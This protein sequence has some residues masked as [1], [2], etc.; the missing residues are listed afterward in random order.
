MP[1]CLIF[2][3]RVTDDDWLIVYFLLKTNKKEKSIPQQPCL[4]TQLTLIV[5][6]LNIKPWWKTAF[7]ESLAHFLNIQM[8]FASQHTICWHKKVSLWTSGGFWMDSPHLQIW[9]LSVQHEECRN[10]RRSHTFCVFSF[11]FGEF[12]LHTTVFHF[13]V[14]SPQR[15]YGYK[16]MC[17][18]ISL[19][20][21]GL[22]PVSWLKSVGRLVI[23]PC[24]QF[25]VTQD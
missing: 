24:R 15:K 5:S 7:V 3:L 11:P 4:S 8:A 18:L 22:L 12:K 6:V 17:H 14:Y 1:L 9:H 2:L 20:L 23:S 21:W 13:F 16:K 25:Q 19:S 10:S